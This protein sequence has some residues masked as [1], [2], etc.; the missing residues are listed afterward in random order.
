MMA[1]TYENSS[2]GSDQ[3]GKPAATEHL[4][5]LQDDAKAA[6]EG[7]KE[8]GAA[9]FEQ[10]RDTAADQIDHLAQTAKS[11]AEQFEENDTLGLSH[12]VTDIAQ[13]MTSLADNL[14]G[15]SADELLR[16]AGQLARENPALFLTGSIAVGFGLSRFLKASSSDPS[17][18]TDASKSPSKA[19]DAHGGSGYK[20]ESDSS[21]SSKQG[22]PTPPPRTDD[23]YHSA[24]PGVPDSF[25]TS[26]LS[27]K[28]FGPGHLSDDLPRDGL[29]KGE[30]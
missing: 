13:G 27:E 2:S 8:H 25:S 11:A 9:Q 10:Y 6:L 23:V 4:Q 22:F 3:G 15:K 1:T 5:H 7:A 24:R 30:V 29:S 20:S 21:A 17:S 19:P 16:Q 26:P 12:Y 14:R 28:A 18:G